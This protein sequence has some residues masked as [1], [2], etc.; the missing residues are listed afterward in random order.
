MAF[1]NVV[2]LI[3]GVG[4]M[5]MQC[6]S[7]AQTDGVPVGVKFVA[8]ADTE[9][10]ITTSREGLAVTQIPT[11]AGALILLARR[12]HDG[13]VEVHLTRS[14]EIM[15]RDGHATVLVGGQVQGATSTMP[16]ELRGGRLTGA[17]PYVMSAGDLI[18]IPAGTPHRFQVPNGA[19]ITY[20]T[21]KF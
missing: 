5:A 8:H 13:D 21:V 12:D 7:N 1:R 14:E 19:S 10:R 3:V 11:G 4:L 9:A 2:A 20:F 18:W 17:H 16:D 6:L 15:V